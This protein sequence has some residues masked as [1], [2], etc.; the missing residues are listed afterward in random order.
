[1]P[2][3]FDARYALISVDGAP[4]P[5]VVSAEGEHV[6]TVLGDTL[7]FRRD[8]TAIR[9]LTF[10]RQTVG[11][12]QFDQTFAL[13]D[14]TLYTVNGLELTRRYRTPCPPNAGCIIPEPATITPSAL[15]MQWHRDGA[16]LQFRRLPTP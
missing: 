12:P 16:R 14:T 11:K 1:M 2:E 4:T 15:T 5:E 10:K 6:T 13:S 8:G 3:R 7:T 9:R